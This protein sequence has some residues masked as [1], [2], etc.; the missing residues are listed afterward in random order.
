MAKFNL[1]SIAEE[2]LI[3]DPCELLNGSVR[4]AIY[5]RIW[6]DALPKLPDRIK[7]VEI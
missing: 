7:S 2:R 6:I 4:A 1:E 3:E 5:S